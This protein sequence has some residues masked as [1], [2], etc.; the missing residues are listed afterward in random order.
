MFT[1][2][3]IRRII[4]NVCSSFNISWDQI[5]TIT[6]DNGTNMLKAVK[7]L[8]SE[9]D[10]ESLDENEKENDENND[11][12]NVYLEIEK[13]KEEDIESTKDLNNDLNILEE[14]ETIDINSNFLNNILTGK[15]F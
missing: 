4:K 13:N 8:S 2:E 6:T 11:N 10:I 12:N 9:Y 15:S 3:Y 1:G 5:Y 7:M 14:I